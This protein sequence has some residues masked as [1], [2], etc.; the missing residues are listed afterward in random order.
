MRTA[1][2]RE[3][4]CWNYMYTATRVYWRNGCA[5]TV[6]VD[7]N[8]F[9]YG[10]FVW[11]YVYVCVFGFV[12]V[13]FVCICVFLRWL[14]ICS[15]V[16]VCLRVYMYVYVCVSV[17]SVLVFSMF[18]LAPTFTYIKKKGRVYVI[19]YHLYSWGNFDYLCCSFFVSSPRPLH[20]TQVNI[21]NQTSAHAPHG[22]IMSIFPHK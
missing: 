8:V 2:S 7:V 19:F 5:L 14:G 9:V 21:C 1:Y 22:L 20:Q 4:L 18:S 6:F 17:F 11:V 15:R 10:L 13:F 12:C 3:L 16:C